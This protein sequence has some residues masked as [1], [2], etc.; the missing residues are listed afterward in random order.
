[1]FINASGEEHYEKG[2]RQN[3]L[4]DKDVKKIVETY[5]FRKEEP[6]YSRQVQLS[7]IKE[8]DYNLNITR[9]VNL[10]KEEEQI[11][12]TT[13]AKQLKETDSKI[14]DSRT[15]LNIFLKELGLEEI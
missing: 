7:E 12:L 11:D 1:M 6:R 5:Q 10:S 9:Y 13:V 14:E 2:K 8:N 3:F 4:R 15:K